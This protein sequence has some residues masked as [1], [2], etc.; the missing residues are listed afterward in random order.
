MRCVQ[1][2][3]FRLDSAQLSQPLTVQGE[4]S[5]VN[6]ASCN[7]FVWLRNS[8]QPAFTGPFKLAA[9]CNLKG[10]PPPITVSRLSM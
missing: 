6:S 9:S 7:N 8:S 3:L 1:A 5:D 10:P 4:F 2:A